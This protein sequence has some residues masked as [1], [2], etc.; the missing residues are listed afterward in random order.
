MT[1]VSDFG[2]DIGWELIT[3]NDTLPFEN[4]YDYWLMLAIIYTENKR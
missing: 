1:F 3:V 4:Y 2:F